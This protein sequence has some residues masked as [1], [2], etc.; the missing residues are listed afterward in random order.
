M[1]GK[2]RKKILFFIGLIAKSCLARSLG[3]HENASY[4]FL[5][6]LIAAIK[7]DDIW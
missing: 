5:P 7:S 2:K 6:L 4:Q 3:C 1:V